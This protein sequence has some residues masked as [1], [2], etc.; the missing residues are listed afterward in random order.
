MVGWLCDAEA[1][2]G[3]TEPDRSGDREWQG[4]GEDGEPSV[5]LG[6]LFGEGVIVRESHHEFVAESEGRVVPTA[7]LDPCQRQPLQ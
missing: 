3:M 4:L 1:T 7:R 6:D 5:F 2:A